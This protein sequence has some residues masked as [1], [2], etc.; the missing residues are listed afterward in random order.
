[1]GSFA[2]GDAEVLGAPIGIEAI[3]GG[4]ADDDDDDRKNVD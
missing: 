3:G 2:I 4:V 1:M